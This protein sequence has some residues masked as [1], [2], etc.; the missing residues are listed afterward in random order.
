MA[1]SDENNAP[2]AKQL[3]VKIAEES[4]NVNSGD[5]VGTT[6]ASLHIANHSTAS[7]GKIAFAEYN[8][9]K[10]DG[11]GWMFL[12]VLTR[13]HGSIVPRTLPVAFVSACISSI[14]MIFRQF[15]LVP[16]E[17]LPI[18]RHP[19]ALQMLANVLG[20]VVV[21]RTNVA[22]S[23]YFEGITNVQFFGS[24]WVDAFSQLCGFIRTSAKC[25]H[26][27]GREGA[28][29]ELQ[30][31]QLVLLHWFSLLHGLA[32]NALQV[33]QLDL[34]E[35]EYFDRLVVCSLPSMDIKRVLK[36]NLGSM[37]RELDVIQNSKLVQLAS[38]NEVQLKVE[39]SESGDNGAVENTEHVLKNLTLLGQL[40]PEE[41]MALRRA[42][43]K[44]DLVHSWIIESIASASLDK[45]ILTQAPILSRVYQELSNGMLGYNQAYKIALVQFPFAFA[46]MLTL[47][48]VA[49]LLCCPIA[50]F[51]FTGGEF[52]TPALTLFTVLGFWGIHEIA[53]E[54]ENPFGVDDNQLPLVPL[55]ES[56]CDT[57]T[58]VTLQCLPMQER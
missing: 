6:S 31:L 57:L 46:Q 58:E 10:H 37:P 29:Q 39:S 5:H 27:A 40:T 44:V 15:R 55:H 17:M 43:D 23:R 42:D 21:L 7:K 41:R 54:I 56:I 52:L 28:I 8:Q 50:V 34:E 9:Y 30:Q 24:K 33:T 49:F 26:F 14:L 13:R 12:R 2:G 45:V 19:I 53:V 18:L 3:G 22:V 25:H 51:V 4:E 32:I 35:D 16:E 36:A 47:F 1:I 11:R 20:Y 38:G 48:L